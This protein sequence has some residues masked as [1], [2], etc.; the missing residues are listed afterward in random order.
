MTSPARERAA[1]SAAAP[2]PFDDD[3]I[4]TEL[5]QARA[6]LL[7]RRS[8]LDRLRAST[9]VAI[10]AAPAGCGKTTVFRQWADEDP[11]PVGWVTAAPVCSDPV[12][13]VRTIAAAIARALPVGPVA[14][15]L[16]SLRGTDSLR[17]LSR[18]CRAVTLDGR[19]VLLVLDNVHELDDPRAFDVVALLVDRLPAT[20]TVAITTRSGVD[21]PIA[22]WRSTGS[23]VESGPPTSRSTPVSAPRSSAAS[24]STRPA[25]SPARSRHA[26]RAG[27]P[28]ST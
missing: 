22:R 25:M 17:N 19:P 20:W 23:V 8:V 27:R 9:R 7:R 26:R 3:S 6:G 11:R 21:L 15:I 4:L 13:L 10:A 12:V 24:A 5:P 16:P 14:D 28:A 2:L 1:P 18:L